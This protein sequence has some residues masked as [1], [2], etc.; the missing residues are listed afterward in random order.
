MD[1]AN[2]LGNLDVYIQVFDIVSFHLFGHAALN[3]RGFLRPSNQG[4]G[5]VIPDLRPS[6]DADT[7]T[8]LITG[9]FSVV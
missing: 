8:A 7:R 2:G 1:C 5:P 3:Y 4:P 6:L 9:Q